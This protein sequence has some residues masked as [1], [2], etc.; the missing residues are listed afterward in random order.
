MAGEGKDMTGFIKDEVEH[1]V[2]K[3]ERSE[4]EL[5]DGWRSQKKTTRGAFLLPDDFKALLQEED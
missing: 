2:Q 3:R 4:E 5:K 1:W